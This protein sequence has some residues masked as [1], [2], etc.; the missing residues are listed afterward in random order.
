M[1]WGPSFEKASVWDHVKLL[2]LMGFCNILENIQLYGCNLRPDCLLCVIYLENLEI[3]FSFH[4]GILE[5]SDMKDERLLPTFDEQV[6]HF[7][8]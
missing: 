5:V 7:I 2:F 3:W 8:S 1:I 4:T 6:D